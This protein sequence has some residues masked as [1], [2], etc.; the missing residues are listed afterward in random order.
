MNREVS[1]GV[2]QPVGVAQ[3]NQNQKIDL[4]KM[5]GLRTLEQDMAELK[6]RSMSASAS[7]SSAQIAPSTSSTAKPLAERQTLSPNRRP[8]PQMSPRRTSRIAPPTKPTSASVP[9]KPVVD[10]T[11]QNKSASAPIKQTN[12]R[13]KFDRLATVPQNKPVATPSAVTHTARPTPSQPS[14]DHSAT[15]ALK[16]FESNRAFNE[17]IRL[18]QELKNKDQSAVDNKDLNIQPIARPSA[19][20]PLEKP[21]PST[22]EVIEVKEPLQ[23]T[24]AP[25]PIKK[26]SEVEKPAPPVET[27]RKPE[28]QTEEPKEKSL[29]K[30]TAED[31]E[32]ELKLVLRKDKDD[33]ALAD[34]KSESHRKEE[35][36]AMSIT[37]LEEAL[38]SLR[39]KTTSSSSRI[40]TLLEEQKDVSATL[41]SLGERQVLIDKNLNPIKEKE[42]A[43]LRDIKNLEE[44]EA[45]APNKTEKRAVERNRWDKETERRNLEDDRWRLEEIYEKLRFVIDRTEQQLKSIKERLES[46]QSHKRALEKDIR[47]TTT[48]RDLLA[49]KEERRLV[50][51]RHDNTRDKI[52]SIKKELADIHKREEELEAEKQD[53]DSKISTEKDIPRRRELEE[54]R[55]KT[56]DKRRETE[57]ERWDKED[58]LKSTFDE[59]DEQGRALAVLNTEADTL[60]KTL[61]AL[62]NEKVDEELKSK[63]TTITK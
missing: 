51:E 20:K 2:A 28:K 55:R 18:E 8:I 13:E 24:V 19:E 58:L 39:L 27:A 32:R 45:R 38:D 3:N 46:E 62:R 40:E 17:Q 11:A 29:E 31:I 56:E 33:T 42:K 6:K 41:E 1:Q 53:I 30:L 52:E 48:E 57:E 37:E 7:T 26:A 15:S 21:K 49:K 12:Y 23:P 35:R 14:K 16:S 10:H 63:P 4:T 36:P 61:R 5:R 44:E 59:R 60:D 22:P 43:I 47:L 50:K 25:E 9:A 54:A 34:K